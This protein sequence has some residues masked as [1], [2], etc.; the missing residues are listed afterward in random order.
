L[1]VGHVQVLQ[2][3]VKVVQCCQD[4]EPIKQLWDHTPLVQTQQT[5]Q[6]RAAGKPAGVITGS[7]AQQQK[8]QQLERPADDVK[9][10]QDV[11]GI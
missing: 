10:M 1:C 2:E 3:A 5:Q 11:G 8:V 7:P 9:G 4:G 6:Q